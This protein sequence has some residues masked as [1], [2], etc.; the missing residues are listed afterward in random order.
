MDTQKE[1]KDINQSSLTLLRDSYKSGLYLFGFIKIVKGKR[2]EKA[3]WTVSML[4]ILSFTFYMVYRNAARYAAYG[5]STKIWEDYAPQRKLPVIT[6]CLESTIG[7]NLRCFNNSNGCSEISAPRI[8]MFAKDVKDD[9]SYIEGTYL[10]NDCYALNKTIEL[11]VGSHYLGVTVIDNDRKHDEKLHILF[12]SPEEFRNRK[13][14]IFM[15]QYSQSLVLKQ[16]HFYEIDIREKH[17]KSKP[18]PYTSNCTE[19][20]D[21]SNMFSTK[22]TYDSC[23][24]TCAYNYMYQK[25]KATI[26]MWKK[27]NTPIKQTVN[28]INRR[29]FLEVDH[30]AKLRRLPDCECN[31]ACSE[32]VYTATVTKD[33]SYKDIY[34]DTAEFKKSYWD[35]NFYLKDAATRIELVPDY[36]FEAFMGSLGGVL[37]LGGKIMATLQLI[38]FLSLCLAHFRKR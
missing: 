30:Y 38:I 21:V 16:G 28:Q 5:V 19:G 20:N 26:D 17:I 9:I 1:Q 34:G 8:R 24:E 27:Y 12:Q 29:C 11:S 31:R 35:F 23:L 32:S 25:C 36:P 6:F 13:E 10:G 7:R 18:A 14:N 15:T 37:G 33:V 4:I 3:F 2:L 22:Y